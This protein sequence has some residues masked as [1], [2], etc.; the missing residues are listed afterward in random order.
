MKK[1]YLIIISALLLSF[2]LLFNSNSKTALAE[3]EYLCSGPECAFVNGHFYNDC[4]HVQYGLVC[5]G[6]FDWETGYAGYLLID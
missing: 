5:C 4:D 6:Q 3:A 1:K 2:V